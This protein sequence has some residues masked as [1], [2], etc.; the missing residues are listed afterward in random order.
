MLSIIIPVLNQHEMT[1]ECILSI[2]E[3][4]E[5]CEIILIDNGSDPSIRLPYAGFLDVQMIRNDENR[6]FPAAANQGIE[7]AKGE[8]IV[9]LNNDVILTPG[10]A[11]KLL[12]ALADFSIVG[13]VTNYCAG[14]QKVA[15][16]PY[17]N[18]EELNAAAAALGESEGNQVQEVRWIIGLCMA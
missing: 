10:W 6:G 12:N 11:E 16:E 4:V 5:D 9:L 17:E 1:A 2:R 14:M 8:M 15:V 7:T 18:K 3:T 13:P